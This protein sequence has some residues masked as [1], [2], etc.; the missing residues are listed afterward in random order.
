MP[1]CPDCK[2]E[3]RTTR[4][5]PPTPLWV[6]VIQ[7]LVGLDKTE[8]PDHERCDRCGQYCDECESGCN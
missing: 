1:L 3:A 7:A 8:S 6:E 2:D 5:G 4:H